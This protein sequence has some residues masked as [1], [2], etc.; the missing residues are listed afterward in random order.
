MLGPVLFLV[1]I[2]LAGPLNRASV[3]VAAEVLAYHL[4]RGRVVIYN[5]NLGHVR[6]QCLHFARRQKV[7][8]EGLEP[9]SPQGQ[10]ILSP[11]CMPFHHSPVSTRFRSPDRTRIE[12]A[13]S[14][15]QNPSKKIMEAA[16]GLE[17][18]DEGFAGLCLTNLAMPPPLNR[19]YRT[20]SEAVKKCLVCCRHSCCELFVKGDYK[21]R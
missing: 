3:I 1:F 4:A 12:A 21:D 13:L 17:P 5:K 20:A 18:G 8:E 7:G 9:S 15:P 2:M 14:T 16:P 19:S 10:R 6:S 11:P